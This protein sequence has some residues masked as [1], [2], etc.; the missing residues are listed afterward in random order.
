MT[1]S[2]IVLLDELL[3]GITLDDV[4]IREPRVEADLTVA[5]LAI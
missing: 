2:H 4:M 3:E 5:E 1:E